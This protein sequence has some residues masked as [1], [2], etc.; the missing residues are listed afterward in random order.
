MDAVGR[1]KQTVESYYGE[2]EN[3]VA[4]GI[5]IADGDRV[6]IVDTGADNGDLRIAFRTVRTITNSALQEDYI[7]RTN[8]DAAAKGYISDGL[9]SRF[10]LGYDNDRSS[11]RGQKPRQELSTDKGSTDDIESGVSSDNGNR[12]RIKKAEG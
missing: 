3:G 10:G 6:Y 11:D 12:G 7:R 8:N 4:D 1:V 2:F 9:S 5:A